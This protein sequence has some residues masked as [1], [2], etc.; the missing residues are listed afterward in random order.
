MYTARETGH[1]MTTPP[2]N[3]RP[4]R[5][6]S[7]QSHVVH[8]YVG[9]NA[10]TFPLQVLGFD[11]DAINSVQFSNHSGYK[12]FLGHGQVLTSKELEQLTTGLRNNGLLASYSHV[13]TGYKLRVMDV[14]PVTLVARFND[15]KSQ[16]YIR[17]KTFLEQVHSLV[18]E[19]KRAGHGIYYVCDPV[20]G[21]NRT[22]Y[23]PKELLPVYQGKLLPLADLITP[24]QYEAEWLSGITIESESDGWEA[25][26]ALLQLGVGTVIITSVQ[27]KCHSSLLL[28]AKS[29]QGEVVKLEIP[30]IEAAFMGS[31]DLFTAL[32]LARINEGLQVACEKAVAC[33]HAIL[34]RTLQSALVLSG[35]KTPSMEQMELRLIASKR[36][37]ENPPEFSSLF[38]K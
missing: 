9:N 21:D 10:A 36:D 8:G 28:L 2:P 7:I 1:E 37:I 19:L 26:D 31:G 33:T 12:H 38:E 20:L 4:K 25:I 3:G 17:E 11:V 35:G 13:L 24:N 18:E 5:V 15:R 14:N 23:V 29:R 16:S 32:L 22:M 34:R 6:L 30:N 27:L